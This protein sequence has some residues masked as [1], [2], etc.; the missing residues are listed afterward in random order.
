M[1]SAA[2]KEIKPIKIPD[3]IPYEEK[4]SCKKLLALYTSDT[5]D[6]NSWDVVLASSGK[7]GTLRFPNSNQYPLL[8]I[9]ILKASILSMLSAGATLSTCSSRIHGAYSVRK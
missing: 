4:Q 5:F 6:N 7:R 1:S 9:E 3:E 2:L 8:E